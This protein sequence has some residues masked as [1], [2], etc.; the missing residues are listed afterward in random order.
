MKT[1][2]LLL[3]FLPTSL[4]VGH[5][6][7][8]TDAAAGRVGHESPGDPDHATHAAHCHGVSS[9]TDQPQPVGVR[10]FP[11]VVEIAAPEF[12]AYAVESDAYLYTEFFSTP[13]TEPPRL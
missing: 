1:H 2:V 6:G 5:W 12:V 3:A 9:C 7:Q 13:P 11:V 10:V 8:F 4:F